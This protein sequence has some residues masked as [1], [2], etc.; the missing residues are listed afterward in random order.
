MLAWA[1]TA[2]DSLYPTSPLYERCRGAAD[3]ELAAQ[4]LETRRATRLAAASAT[5]SFATCDVIRY[6]LEPLI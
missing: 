4:A 5:V 2:K 1:Q 6:H 3:S